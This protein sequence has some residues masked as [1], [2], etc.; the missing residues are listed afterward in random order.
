MFEVIER[1][2]FWNNP[3]QF[4]GL[5]RESY[6]E[7]IT[8][9]IGN[10]LVKVIVGQR[11]V[12]KSYIFR[13]IINHLIIK[14]NINPKNI[15]YI[16]KDLY[17]LDYINDSSVLISVI[18]EY[19]SKIKPIGK[20]YIFID[21]IQEIN[22]WENAVNSISQDYTAEYEV[23]ITGS[24]SNLLSTE[25]STYLT[26]R[27]ILFEV[28]PFGFDEYCDFYNIAKN[29]DSFLR[30]VQE[31]GMPE[32]LHFKENELKRNYL[33]SLKDSILLKDIVN[34][35]KVRDTVILERLVN[36]LIDSVGSFFST[37]KIVKFLTSNKIKTNNETIS[38]YLAFIEN[39]FFIHGVEKFDIKGKEILLNEK[40]YYLN[41]LGFKYYLT[42]GF[43]KNLSRYLENIIYLNLRR[44]G[45]SVSVG[46]IKD[47]EIDF[48]AEKNG[49]TQYIQ[50]CYHLSDETV[51]ER[52]FGNLQLIDD[53][54]EKI[55]VSMDDIS[56]GNIKGIKHI[57]IWDFLTNNT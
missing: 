52:E 33:S 16:N 26:G 51:I 18:D 48:V 31:S 56:I 8:S 45:Y 23:F 39:T 37:N 36:F 50:V 1:C 41:D 42:S 12:G 38:N 21:E 17:E 47:K 43:D 29:K 20:V 9:Y 34:R 25:L 13:M 57:Q 3:F 24:N 7:K 53:N 2:N 40:K 19:K 35:Y 4:N 49:T 46:R 32:T 14:L 27:Y 30:Y 10:P 11:R 54:Y 55:V 15:L 28:F 44:N 6:L 5:K 22:G